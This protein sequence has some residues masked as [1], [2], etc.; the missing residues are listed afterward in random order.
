[1]NYPDDYINRIICG[2]CLEVMREMPDNSITA[3]IT[4]PPY[5]LTFMG[6][7]WDRGIPGVEFWS[8]MLRIAKPGASLMAFGGTRTWHRLGCAIE[9][10]GWIIKDTLCWLY[11]AG[12]PK[13]HDISQALDR[14]AK[15][16]RE[17]I[18]IRNHPTLKNS[19]SEFRQ[20]DN[21]FHGKNKIG[22]Q[23]V[24]TVPATKEAKVWDGYGS[25]FKPA[26]E[27]IILTMKPLD[28]TYTNNALKWSVSGLNI[29][30]GRIPLQNEKPP[31]GSGKNDAWRQR[32]NRK[33]KFQSTN[34]ITPSEGRWP[35]NLL[36]THHPDCT[37]RCV[38]E[39]PVK[40]LDEQSGNRPGCTSPSDA[41]PTSKYRANQ[42]NYMPQGQIYPDTGG[43][44]RFFYTGKATSSERGSY[45]TH[46][47]CKPLSLMR[48]LVT[49]LK[50]P[51]STIILDPFAGSGSTCLACHELGIPFIGIEKEEKYVEIARRRI[52]ESNPSLFMGHRKE[53]VKRNIE[54]EPEPDS[55]MS[56]F[57]EVGND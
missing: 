25:A 20:R 19:R 56:I 42:G 3:I 54:S 26:W 2:D 13:S 29:N 37:D 28:G 52:T 11:G 1:M 35:A 53:E 32:E 8:E 22:D 4:D 41:T 51:E 12:F 31:S 33:D 17:I 48:Y 57:D 43:A 34:L 10:A 45:N 18:C 38:D 7:K 16:K 15:A 46:P 40:M 30:G 9:D 50:M 24:E 47:T 21:K 36:L 6:V 49:L 5:G 27:P 23:W 44:S 39:C 55:Q 14:K